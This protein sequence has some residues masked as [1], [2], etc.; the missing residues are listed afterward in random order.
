MFKNLKLG[1]K[2]GLGFGLVILLVVV[3]GGLAVYN[4]LDIQ[5]QSISLAQEYVP[6]VELANSIERN[7]LQVMY[8]MRGYS[9]KFDQS[10]YDQGQE[11]MAE[12]NSYLDQ[13]EQLANQHESLV[14]LSKDVEVAKEYVAEYDQLADETAAVIE[15]IAAQR[16][17]LDQSAAR[18]MQQANDFL[19]SQRRFF[20]QDLANGVGNQALS[21]RME[22][23]YLLNDAIDYA[24]NARIL[25]FKAQADFN[26]EVLDDAIEQLDKIPALAERLNEITRTQ[27]N[28][29]Q[30]NTIG[31]TRGEY[32]QA[33]QRTKEE[34]DRLSELNQLRDEAANRVLDA[35]QNTAAAGIEH[36]KEISNGAVDTVST[37]VV[38]IGIGLVAAVLLAIIIAV[39][40][41]L[42]IVRALQKGVT[43]AQN[44]SL[45]DL[46]A[47]LEVYQKDEAGIL[48][49][50]L[51]EMQRSLQYKAEKIEQIAHKDLSVEIEKSSEKDGLGDSLILMK[52]SL[53]E[54]LGQVNSAVEQV[55]SG[56]DQVS[57]ASQNLSQGA[58]EQA[59]SL[60]EIT[61]S[62]NEINS[63]SKQNAENAS[64]AHSIAKQAT[65]D[66]E[67]GNQQMNQLSE[68]M[69]RINASS[70]E[71]NKV[72]KVI[73][74]IA[75][76]INLLALNA[77]VEAAR[78]G[79]YGKGF[80]VVADEVRNLAV[81]SADSVK[82][83][84]QMVDET[85][86]NIKQGTEAAEQT[87][88]QLTSIVEGSGKVANFLEEIAQASREQAQA[89]E[90]ITEGLDQID[91]A[92]QSSTASAEESASASEELAGQAQQLRSM[93]A[94]FKLDSRYSGGQRLLTQGNHLSNL[95]TGAAKR[96]SSKQERRQDDTQSRSAE[97]RYSSSDSWGNETGI[98]PVD[99]AEQISLED[100]DFDRF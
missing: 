25:V 41:T 16:Q 5:K 49:D 66:A 86:S 65:Q 28:I 34:Y 32:Y 27:A 82:E 62:T 8:N 42:S 6:E 15:N 60:E 19:D 67:S 22:K 40:L 88:K 12:L 78:A 1:M 87:A 59:S 55:N 38:V 3:V 97:N 43:F 84:T 45:G 68:I 46:H 36:T 10:F 39:F 73:D 51:R 98:K 48:A 58:T 54:L 2:M 18:Y 9:L 96:S 21:E 26:Y 85:V 77:N 33:L 91:Q 80:A 11:Y 47:K 4:M 52:D 14:Q 74:D 30:L 99:P 44:I 93:V 20:E 23:V 37:S 35:A 90:Q 71:I 94:Q 95:N 57:Q 100:D 81:K 92:T 17:I 89:I 69:E 64:E 50:A 72:V 31:E 29:D 13:A 61:S 70:D 7:S 63:Q 76:Q 56:A 83:T 75:F 53:N 79:K 24:N